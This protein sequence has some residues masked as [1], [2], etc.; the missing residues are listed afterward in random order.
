MNNNKHSPAFRQVALALVLRRSRANADKEL[1]ITGSLK[2]R[3]YFLGHK[4]GL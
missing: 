4:N 3:D 1:K 2:N